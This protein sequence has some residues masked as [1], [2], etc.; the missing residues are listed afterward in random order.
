MFL[1]P[2]VF[3]S[4]YVL[5]CLLFKGWFRKTFTINDLETLTPVFEDAKQELNYC[6]KVA[7]ICG[8]CLRKI[9][10]ASDRLSHGR[11]LIVS[12]TKL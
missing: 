7:L 1:P 12:S 9:S 2:F 8:S 6:R 5:M 11:A 10:N 4:C 3:L